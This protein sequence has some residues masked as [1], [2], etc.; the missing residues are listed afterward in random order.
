MLTASYLQGIQEYRANVK[1]ARVLKQVK[2]HMGQDLTDTIETG[3][4][5]G[6]E[7]TTSA[8]YDQV[9]PSEIAHDDA[10]G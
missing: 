9:G 3:Q 2:R 4:E 5:R 6:K 10:V 8:P 7:I 1:P